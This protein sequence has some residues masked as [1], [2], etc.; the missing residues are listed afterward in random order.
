[1]GQRYDEFADYYDTYVTPSPAQ[2]TACWNACS[3]P[4][5]TGSASISA[6]AAAHTSPPWPAWAGA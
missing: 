5:M 2:L 3:A 4:A 1:M 6:A